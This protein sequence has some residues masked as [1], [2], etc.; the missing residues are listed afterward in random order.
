MTQII[1]RNERGVIST[2]PVDI[3]RLIKISYEQF[4]VHKFDN[5]DEMDSLKNTICQ[6]SYKK[7]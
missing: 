3:K 4:Y 6:N 5:L 7:K 2:D 1:I